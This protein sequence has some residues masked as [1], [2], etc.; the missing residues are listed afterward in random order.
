MDPTVARRVAAAV[1]RA[2]APRRGRWARGP[3]A[4]DQVDA[5]PGR[6]PSVL[7]GDGFASSPGR[8]KLMLSD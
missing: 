6:L 3:G 7:R 1:G 2:D 8:S 4:V 5:R